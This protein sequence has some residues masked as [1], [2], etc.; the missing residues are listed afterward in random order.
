MSRLVLAEVNETRC[1]TTN[2]GVPDAC[3][4]FQDCVGVLDLVPIDDDENVVVRMVAGAL[5]PDNDVFNVNV[6]IS[7]A[8]YHVLV[9][10][11]DLVVQSVVYV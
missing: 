5:F 3:S 9:E 6:A 7:E 4:C 11:F 8:S 1:V 10:L 2:D